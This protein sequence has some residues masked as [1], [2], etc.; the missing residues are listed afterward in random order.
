MKHPD[1]S[2][3]NRRSEINQP[4]PDAKNA[5]LAVVCHSL[6]RNYASTSITRVSCSTPSYAMASA[7]A[8]V[9]M[10]FIRASKSGTFIITP[11]RAL[12]CGSTNVRILV[13]P[14]GPKNSRRLGEASQCL[15]SFT[16]G[17]LSRRPQTKTPARGRGCVCANRVSRCVRLAPPHKAALSDSSQAGGALCGAYIFTGVL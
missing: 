14:S 3:P 11:T 12:F 5:G 1:W 7:A 6:G 9:C 8:F 17:F 16:L 2:E 10:A 4:A 13:T 15:T